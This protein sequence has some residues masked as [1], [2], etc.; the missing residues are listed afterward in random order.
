MLRGRI[1]LLHIRFVISLTAKLHFIANVPSD[2]YLQRFR[3]HHSH[4]KKCSFAFL[5]A[6]N[7]E[8]S[9]MIT[10]SK[11]WLNIYKF[12]SY[13]DYHTLH[14]HLHGVVSISQVM[15]EKPAPREHDRSTENRA[16]RTKRGNFPL[17]ELEPT[18]YSDYYDL[19]LIA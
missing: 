2:C 1:N 19:Y 18:S 6:L 12:S 11:A 8:W 14:N 7:W 15:R 13:W 5:I 16:H 3:L 9:Q 4:T 17:I 10:K